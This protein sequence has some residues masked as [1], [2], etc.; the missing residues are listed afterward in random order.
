[1]PVKLE[2]L[3]TFTPIP[4]PL[5][6]IALT[7]ITLSLIALSPFTLRLIPFNLLAP[8]P[9]RT[10]LPVG[11]FNLEHH[12]ARPIPQ[13]LTVQIPT[14]TDNHPVGVLRFSRLEPVLHLVRSEVITQRI[15]GVPVLTLTKFIGSSPVILG[16]FPHVG[17]ERTAGP[18]ALDGRVIGFDHRSGAH[19]ITPETRAP[20]SSRALISMLETIPG[21]GLETDLETD[22][23]PDLETEL[24]PDFTSNLETS[25]TDLETNSGWAVND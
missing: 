24:E 17:L 22:L 6:L 8:L 16:G 2:P 9:I 14:R 25:K 23:E 10:S 18:G 11:A 12:A 13:M 1:L 20:G 19:A 4:I 5:G 15:E 21:T 7:L 3:T